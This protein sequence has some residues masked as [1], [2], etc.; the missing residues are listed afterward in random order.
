MNELNHCA[1]CPTPLNCGTARPCDT[2]RIKA[3][4]VLIVRAYT[5]GYMRGHNDTVE[6]CF[7]DI[8][9][10][11]EDTYFAEEVAEWIMEQQGESA[12]R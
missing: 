11:D 6:S 8:V 4:K 2:D 12:G 3:L 10:T 1:T 5:H 7:T 9:H